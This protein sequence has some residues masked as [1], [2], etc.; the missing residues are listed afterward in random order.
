MFKKILLGVIFAVIA[1]ALIWGGIIR[2]SAK[3]SQETGAGSRGNEQEILASDHLSVQDREKQNAGAYVSSTEN[4]YENSRW[5]Q[6]EPHG[7]TDPQAQNKNQSPQSEIG[8]GGQS[9]GNGGWGGGNG[10]GRSQEPLGESEIEALQFALDDEYLALSTYLSVISDFGEVEPFVSIAISE[11]RH[12]DALVNQFNKYGIPVPDNHYAGM[13]TNF[14][15]LSQACQAGVDAE[16]SNFAL[17]D[18]FFT[19]TDRPDLIRVF[20]NL[21]NASQNSHLPEFESC[22]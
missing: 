8:N 14:E 3:N 20:S 12:I 5:N 2:T 10:G 4:Q 13:E 19:M 18:K 16:S 21:Q 22:S 15:S 6:S 11:Q 9:R 7:S 17:Y 1:G